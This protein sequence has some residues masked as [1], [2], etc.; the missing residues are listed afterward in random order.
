MVNLYLRHSID[1]A[2]SRF[3]SSDLSFIMEMESL[4]QVNMLTHAM[5]S[6]VLHLERF[7]DLLREVDES[8]H[9]GECNGRIITHA[10][11]ELVTDVVPN[12]NLNNSTSR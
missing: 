3:E 6:K 9:S 5:L 7:E 11:Q 10:V 12:Y 1:V 2:I 4:L 8:I